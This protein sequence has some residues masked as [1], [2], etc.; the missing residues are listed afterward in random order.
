MSRCQAGGLRTRGARV[1]GCAGG[2]PSDSSAAPCTGAPIVSEIQHLMLGISGFSRFDRSC[3]WVP[4]PISSA[5]EVQFARAGKMVNRETDGSTGRML[6]SARAYVQRMTG[7]G[8]AALL[9]GQIANTSSVSEHHW[10]QTCSRRR[11]STTECSGALRSCLRA[12]LPLP[13]GLPTGRLGLC[14]HA[15]AEIKAGGNK[16]CWSFN[17]STK[18][19]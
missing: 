3:H 8:Q 7:S 19:C 14:T 10:Q 12:P 9:E 17:Q 18:E 1:A 6:C 15:H 16:R 11:V 4:G 2:E 13:G 5:C